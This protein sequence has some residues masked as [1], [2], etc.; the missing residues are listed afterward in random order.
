MKFLCSMSQC[1]GDFK[2]LSDSV[3]KKRSVSLSGLTSVHKADI[4]YSLCLSRKCRAFC[5]ASDEREAA[6]LSEDLNAMGIR[7][8][9]YPYRD[10][11]FR[12]IEGHSREYEHQ[13]LS[14]LMGIIS[15]EVQCVIACL[16]AATQYTVPESALREATLTLRSGENVSPEKCVRALSL[17]GYERAE[18]IEGVGQFSLRGG[19]LD[20]FSPDSNR[21]VRVEFWGDE[22]DS[23]SYF[24][25]TTQRRAE[26]A[27]EIT[28]SPSSEIFVSDR[29][30]LAKKIE[31]KANL[32]RGESSLKAKEIL[33]AEADD[34]REMRHLSCLDKYIGLIY[35]EKATLIDYLSDDFLVFISE[36]SAAKEKL[37]SA[38]FRFK[39]DLVDYFSEGVLCSR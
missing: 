18:Q 11:N 27:E 31:K 36:E 33:L 30:E 9:V 10:F 25:L 2:R 23:Q 8:A 19:I 7:A 29:E 12:N 20:F 22:I 17:L 38:E 14:V 26:Q 28:L 1:S 13:R 3:V 21:P 16:D 6:L 32:L 5:V 24:D 35:D 37:N 4:I 15:G 39:E 34:I